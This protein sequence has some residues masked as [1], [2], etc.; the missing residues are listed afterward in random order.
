MFKAQ[1]KLKSFDHTLINLLIFLLKDI[2]VALNYKDFKQIAL[3]SQCKKITVI[4]SPHIHKKSRDQFQIKTY[5][6]FLEVSFTNLNTLY[7][8]SEICRKL[9]VAGVQIDLALLYR[10]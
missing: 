8:F 4:R 6:R 3:P 10:Q 2:M 9:R 1:L 5:K 7:A